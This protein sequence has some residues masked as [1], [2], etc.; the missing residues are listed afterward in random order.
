MTEAGIRL[1]PSQTVHRV[2]RDGDLKRVTLTSGHVVE[3]DLVFFAVGRIPKTA[4]LG[5]EQAGVALDRRGAVVVD[6]LNVTS[7]PH[8]FA[9]GT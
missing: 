9:V 5:L 1:H 7:Q 3:A 6:A 8:I 2:E 4:G